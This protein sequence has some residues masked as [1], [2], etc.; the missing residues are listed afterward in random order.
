MAR[1]DSLEL[2][3]D[4]RQVGISPELL[5]KYNQPGPRYTSY[6]TAPEWDD[7]FGPVQLRLAYE[8]ANATAAPLSLYFH[9]PFCDSLCLYCGCNVVISKK[10][11]IAH[12]YLAHLKQ[13]IDRVSS[14]VDPCREVKQLHW[15]GGTPTYLSPEQ[16]EELFIYIRGHF[17]FAQDAEIGVEIDPRATTE[18]QCRL[19]KRLGFNRLSMGI[20][21]FNPL[22]QKTV[23]RVQPYEMTKA[24]FDCC[25]ELGFESIN[26]DL[27]YGL[28]HQTTE[29]F[30]DTVDKI[31]TI[32]P[33]RIAVFSY[34]HVPWMKKQQGSF[35]RFL[36]EGR[37]KFRIW[38][39]AI[40]KL[41]DAGYRY[42]GMDHFARPTDE[43]C[44]A[45]DDRTLHRNFQGYTTK[46]DCDLHGMGVSA[47]SGLED[48]YAQNWRELPRY[49]QA[50]DENRLPTMRGM[51]VSAE[52]KLRRAVINRLLCHCVVVKS[53]IEREFGVRFDEHFAGEISQL[54]DFERDEM[55]S[56]SADRIEVA[57]LGRIFIRNVAMV[58]DEYANRQQTR[59]VYSS[60]L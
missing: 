39:R 57:G 2:S 21:D 46:G 15:G 1:I 5:G 58:F 13:E 54:A 4:G 53:E 34:A 56:M 51:R 11:E 22:V 59:Q 6:P 50:I 25:R 8:R 36:P 18:A 35:A 33:D 37:E 23:H 40:Q 12:S 3:I 29:S 55:V 16:I 48:V 38:S 41:T 20:Q 45:Q 42:I 43:L 19:L 49:Y 10:H 27:I 52:D 17:S 24:L 9:I 31:I 26:M 28:P 32:D 60:T 47:I 7:T 30:S 44:R 14:H